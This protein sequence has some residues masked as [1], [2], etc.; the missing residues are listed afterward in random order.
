MK[1]GFQL[2]GITVS[3]LC[4]SLC[5]IQITSFYSTYHFVLQQHQLQGRGVHCSKIL[6]HEECYLFHLIDNH[7]LGFN[8]QQTIINDTKNG[9]L[10]VLIWSNLHQVYWRCMYT[11]WWWYITP[12]DCQT[13]SVA[14]GYLLPRWLSKTINYSFLTHSSTNIIIIFSKL[15]SSSFF[16][17]MMVRYIYLEWQ[18]CSLG[19]QGDFCAVGS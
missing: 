8:F 1:V 10:V 2:A 12:I 19:M 17:L 11:N 9:C 7:D 15:N 4:K 6:L 5:F 16:W 13:D 14:T 3:N 18:H